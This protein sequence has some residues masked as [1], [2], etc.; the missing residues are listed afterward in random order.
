MFRNSVGSDVIDNDLILIS[1]LLV[2][3]LLFAA[4]LINNSMYEITSPHIP[5]VDPP[6]HASE[7]PSSTTSGAQETS[8][9][10]LVQP[11]EEFSNIAATVLCDIVGWKPSKT[12]FELPRSPIARAHVQDC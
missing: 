2:H 3:I 9:G 5:I 6:T 12:V 8:A 1:M 10:A 11:S 4:L 7:T